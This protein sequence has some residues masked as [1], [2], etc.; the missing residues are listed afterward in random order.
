[1]KLAFNLYQSMCLAVVVFYLGA[2]L[3]KRV[4]LFQT[5]CIPSPV[6]GGII[7]AVVNLLLY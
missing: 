5:Y 4:K 3:K 2:F 1:M 7:F 6:I